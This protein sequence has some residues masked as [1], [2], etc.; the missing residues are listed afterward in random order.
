MTLEELEA[1][2]A[3]RQAHERKPN[4]HKVLQYPPKI[5]EG[6]HEFWMVGDDGMSRKMRR[7][8]NGEIM[9]AD[10]QQEWWEGGLFWD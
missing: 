8:P 7:M 10:V 4:E 1:D 9:P 5:P 3:E 6:V 2:Y